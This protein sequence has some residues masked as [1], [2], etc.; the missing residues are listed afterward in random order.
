LVIVGNPPYGKA[1]LERTQAIMKSTYSLYVDICTIFIERSIGLLRR[2]GKL[3]YIVPVTWETGT[4]YDIFRRIL[5]KNK[6]DFIINLP[7]DVF[8][9]AYVDTCIM[10]L[11]RQEIINPISEESMVFAYKKIENRIEPSIQY[12]NVNYSF[13]AK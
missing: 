5:L 13:I 2:D 12:N 3:G 10:I 1:Q 7:F 11:S 8:K 9:D 6:I 4:M